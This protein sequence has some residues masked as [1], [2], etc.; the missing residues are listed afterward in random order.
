MSPFSAAGLTGYHRSALT[1][2]T[3]WPSLSVQHV[4]QGVLE[5][6]AALQEQ[7]CEREREHTAEIEAMREEHNAAMAAADA[8][9]VACGPNL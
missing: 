7:L 8:R 1:H 4:N 6:L 3:C 5:T 9:W 2:D